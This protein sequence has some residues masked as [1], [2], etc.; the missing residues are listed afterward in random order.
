MDRAFAVLSKEEPDEDLAALAAQLGGSS[1]SRA[2]T[3]SGGADRDG[4]GDRRGAR[5]AR[6][7]LA[8][9]QYEGCDPL[10]TGTVD[11]GRRAP[12]LRARDSARARP[13]V[14]GA[15][16]VLQLLRHASQVDRYES[17]P[18]RAHGSRSA[19]RRQPLLG[20]QLMGQITRCRT[21]EWD[22]ALELLASEEEWRPPDSLPALTTSGIAIHCHRGA[23]D[24]ADR[25]AA[26]L[27]EFETSADVQ[28][29]ASYRPE[30]RVC[31]RCAVRSRQRS[32]PPFRRSRSTSRWAI[33]PSRSRR[34]GASPSRP[35][36]GS[37][38]GSARRAFSRRRKRSRPAFVAVSPGAGD[39][40]ARG[41]PTATMPI[42]STGS[43]PGSSASWRYRSTSPSRCSSGRG[44][45]RREQGGEAMSL[46]TER[47]RSSSAPQ[48][49]P[50][51]TPQRPDPPG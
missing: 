51:A 6:G 4:A 44:A 48:P 47:R 20:M 17:C 25:I 3:S 31:C 45:R 41:S 23:L 27:A 46:L 49:W 39:A 16:R 33:G 26:L 32:R 34:P 36:S 14:G 50:S 42:A 22:A 35:R 40:F 19:S 1:S 7:A 21:R 11:R 18:D 28:E 2:T 8:G 43:P 13:A 29:R 15:A 24:E 9:P 38:T 37:T 12:S 5:P 10:L 30:R